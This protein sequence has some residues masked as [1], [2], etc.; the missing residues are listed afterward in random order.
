MQEDSEVSFGML[1]LQVEKLFKQ[2]YIGRGRL[3][4]SIT[5]ETQSKREG[6]YEDKFDK[7]GARLGLREIPCKGGRSFKFHI[8]KLL[9]FR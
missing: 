2:S 9:D 7:T 8:S 6:I 4:D 3:G 5:E 1:Q